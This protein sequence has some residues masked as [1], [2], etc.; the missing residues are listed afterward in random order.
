M[1]SAKQRLSFLSY[2]VVMLGTHNSNCMVTS[3][4]GNIARITGLCARNSPVNGEFPAQRPVTG[5]F[6]VFFDLRLN[7]QLSKQSWCW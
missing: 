4:N 1:P 2:N 7:K 5:S 6:D 3:A